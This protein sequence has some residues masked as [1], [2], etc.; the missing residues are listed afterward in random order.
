MGIGHKDLI[1]FA[2]YLGKFLLFRLGFFYKISHFFRYTW[3]WLIKWRSFVTWY[4]SDSF[5]ERKFTRLKSCFCKCRSRVK[6]NIFFQKQGWICKLCSSDIFQ[7]VGMSCTYYNKAKKDAIAAEYQSHT[8]TRICLQAFSFFTPNGIKCWDKL[9]HKEAQ[10][11]THTE[12]THTLIVF[13][14][15][16]Q[17]SE[18]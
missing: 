17:V 11:R 10:I 16:N 6:D 3:I 9:L 13:C 14:Y 18:W 2:Y 12:A 5:Q 7:E 8:H 4:L 1:K 15:Q